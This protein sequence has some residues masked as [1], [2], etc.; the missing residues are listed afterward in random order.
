MYFFFPLE[1]QFINIPMKSVRLRTTALEYSCLCVLMSIA[2]NYSF[3][4]CSLK[5]IEI[6]EIFSYDMFK[7]TCI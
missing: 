4:Q 2:I 7:V 5:N 3:L 6:T 1:I